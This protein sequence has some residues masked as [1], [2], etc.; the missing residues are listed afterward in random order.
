MGGQM[1]VWVQVILFVV[2]REVNVLT[3]SLEGGQAKLCENESIYQPPPPRR[4]A[5]LLLAEAM[6]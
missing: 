3:F 6:Y 1:G 2:S 4:G 5:K